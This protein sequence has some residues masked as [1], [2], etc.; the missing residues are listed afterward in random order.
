MK[1]PH[2]AVVD[3]RRKSRARGSEDRLPFA[4]V[5]V[6][7]SGTGELLVE[8]ADGQRLACECLQQTLAPSWQPGDRLL[9]QPLPSP[10]VPVVMGRIG[11]YVAAPDHLC[12][13]AA[14]HLRLQCGESSID[15]RAD[16]KVMIRGDDVLVRAKGTKRIRAGTV[17]IN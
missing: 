13:N 1:T 11:P 12:V 8:T 2:A 6:A 5:L 3:I 15:L 10:A 17:S 4:A 9:V 14:G 16:G 7:I